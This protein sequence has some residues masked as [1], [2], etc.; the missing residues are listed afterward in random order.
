MSNERQI[1]LESI[2]ITIADYRE[3]EIPPID[4]N[5]VDRWVMQFANFGF[6]ENAQK[7][8]LEQMDRIL[9]NYYISR[10][11]AQE[12]ITNVLASQHLFGNNPTEVIRNLEFLRIQAKG[13]SQ[14]DL[15]SLTE[16]CLHNM[17]G[18]NLEDCGK[19]PVIYVYLDDCLYS[20][21]TVRRDIES[22]LP[23]AVEGATLY[24]IFLGVH[25]NGYD[26]SK[27]QIERCAQSKN[28][29]VRFCLKHEFHNNPW[30]PSRFDC[31][32][33]GEM[34]GDEL[35]DQFI[36]K[37]NED[38]QK[39]NKS[40]PPIFRPNNAG[41]QDNIFSSPIERRVIESA[42]LKAGAYIISL[43]KN[44]HSSMR[45]LGYDYLKSLGFGANF[46]TYRNI[47]NN[48]PLALWWGDPN[49]GYPL[50]AWYPL[51][52]RTVN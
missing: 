31:F 1:L 13:N 35:V 21:N 47:A 34:Y 51:F 5:H 6:D 26:Y 22:W 43:P 52:P 7:I 44:P 12:F 3:C 39:T 50:N 15:L 49:K 36:Q 2:A 37:L 33:T 20:G 40:L 30:K 46:V 28:I 25:T 8:I 14:N 4:S 38:R 16:E 42:F 19:S 10:T 9:K 27:K 32:W 17:Y 45:P 41:T 23:S 24:L 29:T 18:L 48:C 11:V